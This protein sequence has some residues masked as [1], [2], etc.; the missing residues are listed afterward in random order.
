VIN[1][2]QIYTLDKS[3]FLEQVSMLPK[4]MLERIDESIKIIFDVCA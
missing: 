1:F 2:S 4:P 3:F